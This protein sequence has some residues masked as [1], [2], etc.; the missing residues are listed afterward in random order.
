MASQALLDHLTEILADRIEK[1]YNKE[2]DYK[3][4]HSTFKNYGKWDKKVTFAKI[5]VLS[6]YF[7]KHLCHGSEKFLFID[8]DGCF[9]AYN[10]R[11]YETMQSRDFIV[12]LIKCT[13]EQL[14]VSLPYRMVAPEVATKEILRT[15]RSSDTYLFTPNRRYIIFNNGVFD[16]RDG[17]L[18]KH[19]PRYVTDLIIDLDYT[20][21]ETHYQNCQEKSGAANA[22]RLWERKLGD[23]KEGIIPNKDMRDA[24]QMFC[25]SL[26]VDREEVKIEYVCYLT[27]PGSNGKSVLASAIAGCFGEQYF[28]WFS[29]KQ[30][31]KDSDARVNIAALRGKLA[32]IVGDLDEH[33][34]SGGDFKRFVSGEKFQGRRNYGDPLLVKAP[35]L[36]CCTNAIPQS[37]DDTHGHH[38]RQLPIYTTKRIWTE[39]DK[40][41]YL[42]QKLRTPDARLAI[43]HWIYE[44]YRKIVKAGGNIPLGGDVKQAMIELRDDS[45]S[46][47]RWFAD[48][49]WDVPAEGDSHFWVSA[50]EIIADYRDYCDLNNER[51]MGVRDIHALLREKGCEQHRVRTGV[52]YRLKRK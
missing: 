18:K 22:C 30:L 25:G 23:L 49:Q 44:G 1:D 9:H 38:R 4:D 36:L 35:P 20:D 39:A 12:E 47:R 33:D 10:G 13:M 37:S 45:N 5:S 42:A 15:L 32:N 41:P 26:L 43:F 3:K 21:P 24:F 11:W 40:D 6:Y 2:I 48:C 31:F 7:E 16:L 19:S 8:E 28:S 46:I 34:I 14:G 50:K 27:G 17:K 52:E 51:K 29:P